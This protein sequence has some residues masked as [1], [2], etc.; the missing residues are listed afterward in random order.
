MDC[1]DYKEIISAHVDRTLSAEEEPEVQSHLDQCPKCKQILAWETKA[2]K[3]LRQRL[4]PL[5]PRQELRQKVLDQLGADRSNRSP[6][7]LSTR[8]IWAPALLILLITASV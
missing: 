2:M 5:A 3:I 8:R 4:S 6:S 1:L 7:W